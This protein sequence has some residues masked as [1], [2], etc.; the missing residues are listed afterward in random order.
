MGPGN[1]FGLG[2]ASTLGGVASNAAAAKFLSTSPAAAASLGGPIGGGGVSPVFGGGG[3]SLLPVPHSP[4]LQTN[5][6]DGTCFNFSNNPWMSFCDDG[7]RGVGG[8]GGSNPATAGTAYN[9]T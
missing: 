2:G 8:V 9:C 3:Q 7:N 5:A 6:I 1:S 4:L